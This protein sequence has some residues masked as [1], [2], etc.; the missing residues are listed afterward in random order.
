MEVMRHAWSM[1]SLHASQQRAT[2]LSYDV[3]GQFGFGWLA[4]TPC[5]PV[6]ALSGMIPEFPAVNAFIQQ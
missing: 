1:K 2:M 3:M 6:S 5:E 4:G